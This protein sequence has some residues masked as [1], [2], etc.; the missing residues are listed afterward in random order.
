MTLD[1]TQQILHSD[2]NTSQMK[3]PR[4]STLDFIR[5]FART[6]CQINTLQSSAMI[7]N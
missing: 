4:K 5:Q 3:T 2:C 6:Y 7:I 1:S